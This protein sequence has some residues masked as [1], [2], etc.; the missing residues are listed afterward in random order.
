LSA[1]LKLANS[2]CR[3]RSTP[4][5]ALLSLASVLG[6][7]AS[8]VASVFDASSDALKTVT[9][10]LGAS[11]VVDGLANAAAS[12]A[13]KTSSSL[14]DTAYRISELYMCQKCG[15]GLEV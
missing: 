11:G 6:T 4:S 1:A 5:P 9:D 8:R 15:L 10:R 12:R 14:G 13:N 3:S 2:L 7:L